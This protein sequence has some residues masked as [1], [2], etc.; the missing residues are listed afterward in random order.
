MEFSLK[1]EDL[2]SLQALTR[3]YHDQN[4]RNFMENASVTSKSG[5]HTHGVEET[6]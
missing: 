2:N 3:E 5:E 4:V 6:G 1:Q